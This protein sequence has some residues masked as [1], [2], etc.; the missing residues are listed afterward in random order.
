[1]WHK[2][3]TAY[4]GVGDHLADPFLFSK[5]TPIPPIPQILK[6]FY[7]GYQADALMVVDIPVL[8]NVCIR[9]HLFRKCGTKKRGSGQ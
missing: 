7:I 5:G 4:K 8:I 9:A 6:S 1:M 2:S 3:G